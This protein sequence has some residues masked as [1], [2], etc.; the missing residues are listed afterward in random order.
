MSIDLLKKAIANIVLIQEN[1]ERI[2]QFS[3]ECP[4]ATRMPL[5]GLQPHSSWDHDFLDLSEGVCRNISIWDVEDIDQSLYEYVFPISEYW[6]TRYDKHSGICFILSSM[7]HTRKGNPQT[8]SIAFPITEV[9]EKKLW[10][11]DDR[12]EYLQLVRDVLEC[13]L[14]NLES[15]NAI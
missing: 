14:K 6:K 11:N 4:L 7:W 12:W 15:K 8:S 2:K 5:K 1:E 3:I 13:A 9:F 10:L